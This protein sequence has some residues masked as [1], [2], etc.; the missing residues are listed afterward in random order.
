MQFYFF[1]LY[2]LIGQAVSGQWSGL[3]RD[4]GPLVWVAIYGRNQE[5]Q[6]IF[7]AARTDGLPEQ[8]RSICKWHEAGQSSCLKG[9]NQKMKQEIKQET[10][11]N[12]GQNTVEQNIKGLR[13]LYLKYGHAVPLLIYGT[14]YLGWFTW[15]ER[16]N[17]KNYRLIH[18]AADDHI[19]FCE[20]FIIPYLLWFAYVSAVVVYLFFKNK[21]DYFRA[22]AF[23]FTGMTVFLIVSTLFPNGHDLRPAVLPRDNIFTAMI[24][25]LWRT[26]TPTNLWPSIHV[27]NSIGAH[28]AVMRNETLRG[29]KGILAGSGILAFSIILSTMLIRQHSVFD[30]LT[31]IAMGAVMYVLVYRREWITDSGT[32][33]SKNKRTPQVG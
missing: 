1:R 25:A 18:M 26:D 21:A 15:L 30:V 3:F 7:L 8:Y 11:Q 33:R 16:T 23:L 29:R 27:Y 28:I 12:T 10:K 20:V 32:Q 24:S 17:T 22:C 19:P 14:V 13:G 6:I 5:N 4:N 31:G 9:T 2:Y